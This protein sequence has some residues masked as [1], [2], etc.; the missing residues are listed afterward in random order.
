[1]I[2]EALIAKKNIRL[3]LQG[4]PV[5]GPKPSPKP[6]LIERPAVVGIMQMMVIHRT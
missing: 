1:M 6:I 4:V 5:H 3:I 2:P